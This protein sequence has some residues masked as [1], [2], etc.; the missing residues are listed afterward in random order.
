MLQAIRNL[1]YVILLCQDLGRMRSFYHDT[2]GFPI[3][4]ELEGWIELRVGAVLLT[5][6]QR[7]RPY[8]G[9]KVGEHAG[10]Q[11]AFRVTPSQVDSCHAELLSR[12]VEILE[13]PRSRE[14]GHR[15]LFF[16]D[17][18]GNILEIYADL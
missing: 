11:L 7:G 18:E 10:V 3:Y 12:G 1:D 8:D 13:P 14:S 16:R 4:R 17:P 6:R 15:T 9:I 2:L 5:L